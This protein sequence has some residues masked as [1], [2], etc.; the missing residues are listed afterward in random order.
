M[1][2]VEESLAA[3]WFVSIFILAVLLS[4]FS[5]SVSKTRTLTP[6]PTRDA[7][8]NCKPIST[9]VN[10]ILFTGQ[11]S[12]NSRLV[13]VNSYGSGLVALASLS[14]NI[15]RAMWSPN[16]KQILYQSLDDHNV[17]EIY[18]MNADGSDPTK[19][20]NVDRDVYTL[21]P[22][23]S[24]DGRKIAF[25][26]GTFIHQ[27][28]FVMDAD[29]SNLEQLTNG[30]ANWFPEWSPDGKHIAFISILDWGGDHSP[31]PT[32]SVIGVVD[33]LT[34]QQVQLI[35]AKP[36]VLSFPVE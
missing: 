11:D 14:P 8:Q 32:T 30:N 23:W 9:S 1:E 33:T 36:G 27:Q 28:I 35:Q 25:G 15:C 16:G 5:H 31:V 6:E 26:S 21:W 2:T 3:K 22:S 18:R 4:G 29:G 34:K 12:L 24:P 13:T 20:T 19:L 10:Q 7:H 17:S